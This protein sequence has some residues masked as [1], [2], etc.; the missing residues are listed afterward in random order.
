MSVRFVAYTV[1]EDG[2]VEAVPGAQVAII[3]RGWSRAAEVTRDNAGA[4]WETV[5]P[6]S[7]GRVA[8]VPPGFGVAITAE[9]IASAPAQWVA[10]TADGTAEVTLPFGDG[11]FFCAVAP[12]ARDRIAGCSLKDNHG[13]FQ[14]SV[15]EPSGTVSGVF[16]VL[17][18]SEIFVYFRQQRAFFDFDD[19]RF[20][21]IQGTG[22]DSQRPQGK[23][24]LSIIGVNFDSLDMG[25][26][27]IDRWLMPFETVAV[28]ED[29]DAGVFWDSVHDPALRL[30]QGAIVRSS[31]GQL[32]SAPARLVDTGPSGRVDLELEP[33][34]YLLCWVAVTS[35][36][37]PARSDH[38]EPGGTTAPPPTAE[39][40]IGPCAHTD[41]TTSQHNVVQIWRSEHRLLLAEVTHQL[42]EVPTAGPLPRETGP[43]AES[44][45]QAHTRE[46]QRVCAVAQLDHEQRAA[47]W[48]SHTG[49][50]RV[51]DSPSIWQ[52]FQPWCE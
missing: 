3:A 41:I 4:F 16:E 52:Q 5:A 18:D 8:G 35:S 38:D 42:T 47:M 40:E 12:E 44:L 49:H 13:D 30:K 33:G 50:D 43:Y 36:R 6:E 46:R 10:T 11:Y 25:A 27:I 45:M 31:Y 2:G 48:R 26:R 39:T 14:T 17:D 37:D 29:A 20:R 51:F 23:A 7:V 21:R 28:V 22:T 24:T 1:A 19:R 32:S 34:G 9:R 15:G